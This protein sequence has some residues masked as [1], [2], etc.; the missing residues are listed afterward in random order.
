M[1]GDAIPRFVVWS[2]EV[3]HRWLLP[4]L[5]LLREIQWH[6]ADKITCRWQLF[7]SSAWRERRRCVCTD[8]EFMLETE[9]TANGHIMLFKILLPNYSLS[10]CAH[11]VWYI[12]RSYTEPICIKI[13]FVK[14]PRRSLP[15]SLS[16]HVIRCYVT[17]TAEIASLML[18]NN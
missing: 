3:G 2:L 17:S 5:P 18:P 16:S 8:F 11:Y 7:S 10:S 1:W 14:L 15:K 12:L 9:D 13:G 4:S 6:H